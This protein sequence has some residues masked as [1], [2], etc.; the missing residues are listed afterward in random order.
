LTFNRITT[1]AQNDLEKVTK[2]A[3]AQIKYFGFNDKVGL[4]SFDQNEGGVKP[5][6]K[7]LQVLN[8][9]RE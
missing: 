7:T 3:Y 6:S 2:M 8:V 5:Y 1:G 4:L 9:F